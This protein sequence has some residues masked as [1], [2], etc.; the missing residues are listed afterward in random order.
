METDPA[1]VVSPP[2]ADGSGERPSGGL[3]RREHE[4]LAFERQ[5]WRQ[6]GAKETA[7][8]ERFGVTPT[9]YYQVLNALVDQPAALASDPLLVGRLRRVRAARRRRRVP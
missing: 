1:A 3:T 6:P 2:R 4:M 8:R 7:I 5:W 9:R